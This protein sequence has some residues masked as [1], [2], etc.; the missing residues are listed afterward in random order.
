MRTYRIVFG[1]LAVPMTSSTS[2]GAD[3]PRSLAVMKL[4]RGCFSGT[5][6]IGA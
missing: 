6:T 1:S 5:V 4:V 3:P 2:E